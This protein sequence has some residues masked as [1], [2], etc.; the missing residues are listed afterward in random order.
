MICVLHIF[1]ILLENSVQSRVNTL[2]YI[3]LF[4][5]KIKVS[6]H[7]AICHEYRRNKRQWK[8]GIRASIYRLTERYVAYGTFLV[9]RKN[10]RHSKN[11]RF[12]RLI[13]RKTD[14]RA[15]LSFPLQQQNGCESDSP[16]VI[17]RTS[18]RARSPRRLRPKF[19]SAFHIPP[20]CSPLRI[21]GARI[22]TRGIPSRTISFSTVCPRRHGTSERELFARLLQA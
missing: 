14:P 12:S 3:G 9:S 7:R 8:A 21:N 13:C 16:P 17:K 22:I 15:T 11:L 18:P 10:F 20:M 1:E 5:S 19:L 6:I 2:Y 4:I